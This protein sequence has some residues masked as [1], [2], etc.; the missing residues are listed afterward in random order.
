MR[1]VNC[2]A[3]SLSSDRF[4][5]QGLANWLQSCWRALPAPDMRHTFISRLAENPNERLNRGLLRLRTDVA[6]AFEHLTA[7]V[8]RESL[9]RLLAHEQPQL[10]RFCSRQGTKMGTVRR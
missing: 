9:D 10:S 4:L 8:S 5:A 3:Y 2:Q 1:D 7:D 6:V